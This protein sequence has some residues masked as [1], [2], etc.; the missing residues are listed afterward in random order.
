MQMAFLV[1]RNVYSALAL[2]QNVKP[3][4]SRFVSSLHLP[5]LIRLS[6]LWKQFRFLQVDVL[7]VAVVFAKVF[8]GL[9]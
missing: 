9:D 8:I 2:L 6:R 5:T 1:A 4:S 7:L 3:S